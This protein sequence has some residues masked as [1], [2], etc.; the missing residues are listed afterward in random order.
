MHHARVV[1][2]PGRLVLVYS[3]V[4]MHF[5]SYHITS[6]RYR[7]EIRCGAVR[8]GAGCDS[9]NLNAA[10]PHCDLLRTQRRTALLFVVDSGHMRFG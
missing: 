2:I 4:Q 9:V 10:V 3:A 7:L 6:I 5:R 1:G 8:C